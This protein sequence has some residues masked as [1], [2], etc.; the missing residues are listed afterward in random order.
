MQT[1]GD[2]TFL[3]S[4]PICVYVCVYVKGVEGADNE[5]A[6]VSVYASHCL[7]TRRAA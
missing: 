7:L 2:V 3:P 1:E 5:P 6:L 4:L